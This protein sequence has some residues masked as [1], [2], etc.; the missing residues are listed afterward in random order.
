MA[1][2]LRR[3]QQRRQRLGEPLQVEVAR[4]RLVGV[5]VAA[6]LTA[7]DNEGGASGEERSGTRDEAG[8]GAGGGARTASD[9]LGVQSSS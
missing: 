3:G 6:H 9:V 5:R 1:R 8:R 4:A 7:R 2:R